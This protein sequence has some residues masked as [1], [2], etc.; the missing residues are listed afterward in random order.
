MRRDTRGGGSC[1]D[2]GPVWQPPRRGLSHNPSNCQPRDSGPRCTT[3]GQLKLSCQQQTVYQHWVTECDCEIA[4]RDQ[5]NLRKACVCECVYMC[6]CVSRSLLECT[7][8]RLSLASL[9][10]LQYAFIPVSRAVHEAPPMASVPCICVCV[11]LP[12]CIGLHADRFVIQSNHFGQGP[13]PFYLLVTPG[14]SQYSSYS[15]ESG[16]NWARFY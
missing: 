10:L 3:P 8:P 4:G 13:T 16:V 6:V 9:F 2:R 1:R 14:Q 5:G 7:E 11:C 12:P 15:N